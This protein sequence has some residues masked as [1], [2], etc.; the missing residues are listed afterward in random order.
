MTI[1]CGRRAQAQSSYG[2]AFLNIHAEDLHVDAWGSCY[3]NSVYLVQKGQEIHLMVF[4]SEEAADEIF[5]EFYKDYTKTK[6]EVI[7]EDR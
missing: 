1:T 6:V 4:D 7:D 2:R 3:G 5:N